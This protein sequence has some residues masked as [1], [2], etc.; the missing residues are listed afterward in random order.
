MRGK[1][2][3]S[4]RKRERERDDVDELQLLLFQL[5]PAALCWSGVVVSSV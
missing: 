3:D 4:R 1:R 2:Q 5:V